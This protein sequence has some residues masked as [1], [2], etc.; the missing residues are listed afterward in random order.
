ME[1]QNYHACMVYYLRKKA[2]FEAL[3]IT[4]AAHQTTQ[5]DD[6]LFWQ[7]Y[8]HHKLKNT[9][10]ADE[11][12]NSI[13]GKTTNL[14]SLVGRLR[15][16]LREQTS[17]LNDTASPS[18]L[19]LE[20]F[21]ENTK[22]AE[23]L[24][25]TFPK[26][27]YNFFVL[28]TIFELEN[29]KS[30]KSMGQVVEWLDQAD[31]MKPGNALIALLRVEVLTGKKD[32]G[33][34][35]SSLESLEQKGFDRTV[36]LLEKAMLASVRQQWGYL[37]TVLDT[38]SL[39]EPDNVIGLK[40][41]LTYCLVVSGDS[42]RTNDVFVYF[43]NI[44][45]KNYSNN[46]LPYIID[47]VELVHCLG[48]ENQ[49]VLKNSIK[50]LEELRE[51]HPED[52]DILSQLGYAYLLVEKPQKARE[53]YKEAS[54]IQQTRQEPL[55]RLV[56]CSLMSGD[57]EDAENSLDFLRE[58][59]S[60]L[61]LEHREIFFLNSILS[62]K[63][64]KNATGKE[65]DKLLKESN[66]F[67][68]KALKLHLS[69]TK[70]MVNDF[71]FFKTFNPSF[72]LLVTRFF[73]LDHELS[74]LAIKL[75]LRRL[76][77]NTF[78]Y[79]KCAKILEIILGKI[80][81]LLA[82]YILLTKASLI[83]KD[84][85]LAQSYVAK[86]L[87]RDSLHQES[88]YYELFIALLKS[89]DGKNVKNAY[90]TLQ[91]AL[92][93]NFELLQNPAFMFLK[94]QAE[95]N[96]ERLDEAEK[97]LEKAKGLADKQGAE[98][99]LHIEIA[100]GLAILYT[101]R[102]DFTKANEIIQKLI[103]EHCSGNYTDLI[104]LANSE[105]KLLQGDVKNAVGILQNVDKNS[106]AFSAARVKLADIYLYQ[107]KLPRAYVQCFYEIY[108]NADNEGTRLGYANALKET[109]DF[110]KALHLYK[111]L[112]READSEQLALSM[113][114]CLTQSY[115][116][117]AAIDFYEAK[118]QKFSKSLSLLT[119]LC[120]L[121]EKLG[122][123]EKILQVVDFSK[124]KKLESS[125]NK[126]EDVINLAL[127]LY[128]LYNNKRWSDKAVECIEFC[129]D[130]QRKR[131]ETAKNENSDVDFQRQKLSEL[132][133]CCLESYQR[134]NF[135]ADGILAHL[136][137]ALKNDPDNLTLQLKNAQFYYS[138]K[139]FDL[140]KE[141]ARK[142]LRS[143][144]QR[145]DA[146]Q[147][148]ADCLLAKQQPENGIKGFSK[149]LEK[150]TAV[151]SNY[152]SLSQ[153]IWFYRNAG[154][155]N[156][157]KGKLDKLKKTAHLRSSPVFSFTMGLYNYFIRNFNAALENLYVA[158]QH[159]SFRKTSIL[160]MID[161]YLHPS[162][163][164]LYSNFFFKE[165]LR[166]PPKKTLP[167]LKKLINLLAENNYEAEFRLY[168]VILSFVTDPLKVDECISAFESFQNSPRFNMYQSLLLYYLSIFYLKNKEKD[169]LKHTL[170]SIRQLG[171][172]PCLCFDEYFFKA[173]LLCADTLLNK[174]K[175][176]PAKTL[177]DICLAVNKNYLSGY[178]YL[179][180]LH[181][182]QKE[183]N[184][185]VLATAFKLTNKED[186]NIGYKYAKRLMEEGEFVESFRVCKTVLEKYPKFKKIEVDIL[187][188][189]K[190]EL[191]ETY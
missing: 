136:E 132:H 35:E 153:L 157:F 98:E 85:A 189:V 22:K 71:H 9:I 34:A 103:I 45:E 162:A 133:I 41:S 158:A 178:E 75:N 126:P 54:R 52:F 95:M 17:N 154:K 40:S 43:L 38:L 31:G 180:L 119:Q 36:L 74:Y 110:E 66:S 184:V 186:P 7:A 174:D 21:E 6:Y 139:N 145:K 150:Q 124:I 173:Q 113:G 138:L 25:S 26:S 170:I 42:T 107:L 116:F 82:G 67:F 70:I 32:F 62:F 130:L 128:R 27:N 191:L 60:S 179:Y 109:Q 12:F 146:V 167:G 188:K 144:F 106:P 65:K 163:Y 91:S 166:L 69:S 79:N 46:C 77:E 156:E 86:V 147:L 24:L 123:M 44:L 111:E 55:I 83:H 181:T 14:S 84:L 122:S 49:S 94:S 33:G 137:E 56:M 185:S 19:L 104:V 102:M 140:A 142:V 168:S 155:L 97:T 78:I 169:K 115:D 73:M 143:D 176:K 152:F 47:I 92:S 190:K 99:R 48:A 64:S 18:L 87:A 76:T 177:I 148:L 125:G 134:D 11:L 80:P 59:F 120:L 37:S 112:E 161:I 172:H 151:N 121:Y 2:Y 63:K 100:I 1:N 114:E 3:Q 68:D 164:P 141:K 5:I 101:K 127:V 96:S 117:P 175:I 118:Q 182:K 90:K 15:S 39:E 28:K 23:K 13:E 8:C 171:Y 30:S 187:G 81:G 183:E 131:I 89:K 51:N 29:N 72:L 165:K 57:L 61:Q 93:A 53:F 58:V 16:G 108:K 4:T 135:D 50:T 88:Y 149:I 129:I 10:D 159:D 160:I 105:V 20:I